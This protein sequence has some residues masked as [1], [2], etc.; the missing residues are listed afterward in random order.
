MK[1]FIRYFI[2]VI[3]HHWPLRSHSLIFWL[4]KLLLAKTLLMTDIILLSSYCCL[5]FDLLFWYPLRIILIHLVLLRCDYNLLLD[6][7]RL[8]INR[9]LLLHLIYRRLIIIVDL[10]LYLMRLLLL[11]HHLTYLTYLIVIWN[12][13]KLLLLHVTYIGMLDKLGL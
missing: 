1:P 9:L 2:F 7:R 3:N 6:L 12:L 10:V 8:N 4:N 11:I 5:L 13:L